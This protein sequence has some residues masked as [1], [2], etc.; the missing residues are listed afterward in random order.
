[1]SDYHE[2]P[3]LGGDGDTAYRVVSSKKSAAESAPQP[4]T[5]RGEGRA[6]AVAFRCLHCEEPLTPL[7]AF[8]VC[9]VS[10]SNGGLLHLWGQDG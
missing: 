10:A 4:D 1:M 8:K 9:P 2:D 6:S 3:Y 7:N 5:Q